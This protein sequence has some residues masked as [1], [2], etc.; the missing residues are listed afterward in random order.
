MTHYRQAARKLLFLFR[1]GDCLNGI[2]EE[3][4]AR[5]FHLMLVGV[6]CWIALLMLAVAVPFFV[7]RRA[8]VGLA[9]TILGAA[10]LGALLLVRS[11]RVR[12][13]AFLF[14]ISVWC[15]AEVTAALNGGVRS[16][17]YSLVVLTIVNAGWLLGR[18]SAIALAAATLL[19]ALGEALLDYA[20]RPLPLYFP[21]HPMGLWMVLAGILL[22]AVGP[23]LSILHTLRLQVSALGE[24]EERYRTIMDAVNDA[25]F[26]DDIETGRILE[27]NQS[28]CEMFGFSA[29][30][31]RR[32]P[33]GA[34]AE[35][36]PP[37]SPA[38]LKEHIGRLRPGVPLVVGWRSRCR[39]GRLFWSEASLRRARVRGEERV[40]V[41]L[42][43]ITERKQAEVKLRE[44][45][46]ELR[47]QAA[48]IDLSHDAIIIA[49]A[50]RVITAWNTGAEEMY[51]WKQAEAVGNTMQRLL[52][53]SAAVD[54]ILNRGGRWDGELE[55]LRRDGR[56]VVIDSRQI[57]VRE[58]GA[59]SPA[60]LLEINRDITDRRRAEDELRQ[61]NFDLESRVRERT[62]QLEASNQE[63]DNFASSISHDL[64]APLR[65]IDGWSL[66]LVEDVGPHLDEEARHYLNRLRGEAQH[67]GRLIDD[68]L[69]L[70]RITRAPFA[71]EPVDLTAM[72]RSIADTLRETHAGRQ[73]EFAIQPGLTA[74]GDAPL[75]ELALTNLL[76]NAVKFTGKQAQAKVEMGR[77]DHGGRCAFYVRDNGAG[78]NMAY[79]GSLFRPF[80]RLH[81][82]SDFP[83]GGIGLA[84]VE[85]IVHRHGGRAWAD[86]QVGRGATFYFTLG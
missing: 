39:D 7:A 14:I 8:G 85:R 63:L 19:M 66:A 47:R 83:G 29:E 65:G 56:R 25:I 54:E 58:N 24:S 75:L 43:D 55:H 73:I 48:L 37:Y 18:S 70:S 59:G 33:A 44:Q 9:A 23:I 51:G 35:G 27:V 20:G 3:S 81:N 79:A 40:V 86:A 15:F 67:M 13:A 61:L 68:L 22:F 36:Q 80:Q 53:A 42:R 21:G 45:R 46:D 11:R 57:L 52:P 74:N 4:T 78:F 69:R 31:M 6:L 82:A 12:P 41:V 26:V 5:G 50:N 10:M 16:V 17:I 38:E 60:A 34:L 64:R 76:N 32:L 1:G 2:E 72:A 49:D 62:A 28:A 71:P 77:T 30:E 84:T